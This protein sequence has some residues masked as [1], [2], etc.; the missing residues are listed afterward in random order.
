MSKSSQKQSTQKQSTQKKSTQKQSTQKEYTQKQFEKDLSELEL[1]IKSNSLK[2]GV[3][4]DEEEENNQAA[5]QDAIQD[6][7]HERVPEKIYKEDEKIYEEEDDE[8]DEEEENNQAAKN[9]AAKNQAAKNQFAQKYSE[10]LYELKKTMSLE[11]AEA[12]IN[13]HR[14][15]LGL[16]NGLV[17]GGSKKDYTG[18]YRHFKMVEADGKPV[19]SNARADIKENQTPL[20]AAKKLL[21]SMVKKEKLSDNAKTKLKVI[22]YIQETNRD[23]KSKIYGPYIGTYYKYSASEAAKAKAAKGAVSFKFKPIVKL[24]KGSKKEQK[25]GKQM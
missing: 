16:V 25:G 14:V 2:G 7:I 24:Y 6:A 12:Y 18:E 1:L 10:I 23:S 17:K 8:D 19:K 20:N 4:P 22:F 3:D 9:Q 15:K 5:K 13:E 11:N 21:T